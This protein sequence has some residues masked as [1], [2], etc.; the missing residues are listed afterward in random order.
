MHAR[1]HHHVQVKTTFVRN[2]SLVTIILFRDGVGD[3]QIMYVR[4]TEVREIIA[5]FKSAGIE[6]VKFSFIIV[7]KRINH[8]FFTGSGPTSDNPHS[9]TIVDDVVTDP[10]RFLCS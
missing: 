9:G 2:F 10:Q 5:C 1:A 7:S 8:R 3:G 6:N 4:D